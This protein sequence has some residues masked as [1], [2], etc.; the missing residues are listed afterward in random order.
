M[1]PKRKALS[2]MFMTLGGI[3]FLYSTQVVI[4]LKGTSPSLTMRA[5][6]FCVS[7]MPGNSD[8][9]GDQWPMFHGALNHTGTVRTIPIQGT[10]PTWTYPK[11]SKVGAAVAG[12]RVYF[13]STDN[14]LYCLNATSGTFIWSHPVS[15]AIETVPAVAGGRVY[16]GADDAK[17]Y[18]LNATSGS[19]VWDYPTGAAFRSSP[20]VWDGKVYASC[21]DGYFYCIYTGNGSLAWRFADAYYSSSGPAVANGFAYSADDIARITQLNAE[22]GAEVW[23]YVTPFGYNATAPAVV[24][25]RLFAG[26]HG[27]QIYC[28]Y[29]EN[30][31]PKWQ[32]STNNSVDSAP[33]ISSG[34]A[35]FGCNDHALHCVGANN[36]ASIWSYVTGGAVISSPAI[37]VGRV[38]V[39]S[40]DGKVYC[41]NATTGVNLW[42]Y[43]TGNG[44][45]ASPAIAG[46]H[47]FIPSTD[48]NFYCLPTI[49]LDA[50]PQGLHATA[51]DGQVS[52]T[53][54][55]PPHSYSPLNEYKIYRATST[56]NEIFLGMTA[57][58]VTWFND[59]TV[60]NGRT[61]YYQVTTVS[62]AGESTRSG[63]VIA[64]PSSA[65]SAPV[66]L[67]GIA[68]NGNIHLTWQASYTNTG[69]PILGY[70]IYRGTSIGGE[71]FFKTLGNVLGYSDATTVPG[72]TYSY[73]VTAFNALT[74]GSP[75]NEVAITAQTKPGPP[76]SIIAMANDNQVQ[77]R[78][79]APASNGWSAILGYNIYRGT[80]SNNEAYY[81]AFGN[82]TSY[83]DTVVTNGQMYYYMVSAIN[84]IGEGVSS[85]EASAKPASMP[86]MPTALQVTSGNGGNVIL[87]WLVPQ[88]TGGISIAGYKVYRGTT[89]GSEL[90]LGS[91]GNRTSYTDQS[92]SAGTTYYY[93]V[94][95]LNAVGESL[96]SNEVT[97]TPFT[98]PGEPQNLQ[99]TG[100]SGQVLLAWQVPASSGWSPITGYEILRG[101]AAG[102]EAYLATVDN[103]TSFIDTSAAGEQIFYYTVIAVN[104]AGKSLSSTEAHAA[105]TAVPANTSQT[106][107]TASEVSVISVIALVCAATVIITLLINIRFNQKIFKA[108]SGSGQV[109]GSLKKGRDAS[110]Y[111]SDV[112]DTA[113]SSPGE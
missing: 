43:T 61:Y 4:G 51:Y 100:E 21:D 82:V 81:T 98:V 105:A 103:V 31:T 102:M 65:P 69:A 15:K 29:T 30:S 97:L 96:P 75:S 42:S 78:W 94:T 68:S 8:Q 71:S 6:V 45:S 67:Q 3:F 79:Q 56:G 12:G 46:G 74:E 83:L 60:N 1:N 49:L 70:R 90:L 109:D 73:F 91:A 107:L 50:S 47:I 23:S 54:Q 52:L 84:E 62:V 9:S 11:G 20:A 76:T 92:A 72:I 58:N 89:A 39:G 37:A 35:Y 33:A 36:G 87:S 44:V 24:N 48:G 93:I 63:E 111:S 101:T 25:D 13:G 41:F 112:S 17:I 22:T 53:W 95:A 19:L 106:G 18:C 85:S 27:D 2:L 28:M 7:S 113:G 10:S 66:N 110:R 14:T 99:A 86:G 5:P 108:L 34:L 26:L 59:T 77:L 38:Y 104:A 32:I 40:M 88:A 64:T 55:A 80:I 16:F 57:G